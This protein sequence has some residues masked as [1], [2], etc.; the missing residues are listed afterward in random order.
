MAAGAS[1]LAGWQVSRE[2]RETILL[3][4][5]ASLLAAV[6]AVRLFRGRAG[7]YGRVSLARFLLFLGFF[8]GCGSR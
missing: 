5:G 8:R 6:R 3:A 2:K 4:A 1:S 7:V